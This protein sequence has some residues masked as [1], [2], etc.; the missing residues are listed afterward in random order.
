MPRRPIHLVALCCLLA[1]AAAARAGATGARRYADLVGREAGLV[2]LWRFEGDLADAQGA[3]AGK[4]GGGGAAFAHRPRGGKALA[5]RAGRHVKMGH[6]PAHDLAVPI[7]RPGVD[8]AVG[9]AVLVHPSPLVAL[10]VG[11]ERLAKLIESEVA[12]AKSS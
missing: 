9:V 6:A 3:L 8:G 1:A 10:P 2:A 12:A 7:V 11:V 4:A 5:D